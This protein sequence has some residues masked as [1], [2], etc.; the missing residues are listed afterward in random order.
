[1]SAQIERLTSIVTLVE[2]G[3]HKDAGLIARN[4]I[5]GMCLL[6]WAAREPLSR[7][8]LWRSYALVQDLQLLLEK[9]KAGEK[10]DQSQKFDIMNQLETYGPNFFSKKAEKANLKVYLCLRISTVKIGL[11]KLFGK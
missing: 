3:Q 2:T 7:S 5:E 8:L 1:V 9:E 10:I 11:A 4:M 6:V